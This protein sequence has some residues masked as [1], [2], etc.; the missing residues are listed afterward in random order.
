[1][2]IQSLIERKNGTK[3]DFDACGRWPAG[4]YHFKPRAPGGPHVATVKDRD[5]RDRFLELPHAFRIYDPD[6]APVPERV[7]DMRPPLVPAKTDSQPPA[8]A[9]QPPDDVDPDAVEEVQ[10]M[11]VSALKAKINTIP[12]PV[13]RA[14]LAAEKA[15]DKPRASWVQT[16]EAFL[17]K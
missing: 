8:G 7:A 2:E 15:R 6:A 4:S 13:L 1:M 3:V 11:A 16:V 10:G 9:N 17:P 14:A 5:H 12:E